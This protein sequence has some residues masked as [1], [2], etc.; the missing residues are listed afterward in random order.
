MI[1]TVTPLYGFASDLSELAIAGGIRISQQDHWNEAEKYYP[2]DTW[3][4]FDEAVGYHLQVC[5]PDYILWYNPVLTRDI[6]I[7][8]FAGLLESGK[9][10][11]LGKMFLTA[12]AQLFW[13]FRL[14][15]PGRLRAGETF[16]I[17]YQERDQYWETLSSGRAA[18]TSVDYQ[19]LALKSIPYEFN[20]SELP[21]FQSFKERLLPLLQ[22]AETVPS[23][24]FALNI[25]G[26]DNS[27]ELDAISTVTALEGL[28]TK[29][30]ETEGLTY[31]LSMRA[32]NLLGRDA[33]T[34]KKI[35]LETKSFY[36]LRSRLVH[37]AQLDEKLL[38]RL[39]E[40]GS[41]REMLRRVILSAISLLPEDK[42]L[43]NLPERLDDLAFDDEER[44]H[45]HSLADRFFHLNTEQESVVSSF[46]PKPT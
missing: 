2:W 12:T 34:R 23:L 13:L 42:R 31:R 4:A 29:K 7:D 24:N 38:N 14:F 21:F 30:D 15:K 32:A 27:R 43:A 3:D 39:K 19:R 17:E 20:S 18:T 45:V 16:V 41:L 35:F 5:P 25:Y 1:C 22:L 10:A 28:L 33:E 44:K 9:W 8:D 6:W 46:K 11:E 37:G 36:N 40:L 26:G